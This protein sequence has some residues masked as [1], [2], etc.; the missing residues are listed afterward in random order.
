MDNPVVLL[1]RNLVMLACLF[2]VPLV[3]LLGPSITGFRSPRLLAAA[4]TPE[5]PE[6]LPRAEKDRRRG[7]SEPMGMPNLPAS[8]FAQ[9]PAELGNAS[10]QAAGQPAQPGVALADSPAARVPLL[11]RPVVQPA[12]A[13]LAAGQAERIE[14]AQFSP[15]AGQPR[16]PGPAAE[17]RTSP[18]RPQE[19]APAAGIAATSNAVAWPPAPANSAPRSDPDYLETLTSRLREL[20]AGYYLLECWGQQ[21]KVYRFYCQMGESGPQSTSFEAV[22]PDQV[23]AVE[24]VLDQAEAWSAARSRPALAE[25]PRG[26]IR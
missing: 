11:E 26:T 2:V 12:V 9:R 6:K 17:P 24:R 7:S 20:G 14:R 21:Q 8:M 25:R 3:A 19:S 22:A 23:S 15:S 1:I 10:P 16:L 4:A 18:R 13:Q 5:S